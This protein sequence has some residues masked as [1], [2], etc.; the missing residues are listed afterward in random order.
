MRG[1]PAAEMAVD[2]APRRVICICHT[3]ARWPTNARIFRHQDIPFS[4]VHA[5]A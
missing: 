1:N 2:A 4:Y 5:L 3:I